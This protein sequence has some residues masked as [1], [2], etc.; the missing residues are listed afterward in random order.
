M[1]CNPHSADSER[2]MTAYNLLKANSRSFLKRDTIV[3]YL[4]ARINKPP[5]VEFDSHPAVLQWVTDKKRRREDT[6]KATQQDW[7]RHVFDDNAD[8]SGEKPDFQP[9]AARKF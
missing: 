8:D 7:L 9:T 1:V 5:L 3:D 2:L 6:P 4:Y